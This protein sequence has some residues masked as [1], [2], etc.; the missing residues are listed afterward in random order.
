MIEIVIISIVSFFASILTFFSGFG[1][2]TILTPVMVLFFPI[3]VAIS[4][5]AVVHLLNNLFKIIL[6]GKNVNWKLLAKFGFPAIVGAFFGAKLLYSLS[7]ENNFIEYSG[8]RTYREER[9]KE[10]GDM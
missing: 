3:E 8:N 4:V 9:R 2:G 1:L 7:L 10:T 5:T 6:I